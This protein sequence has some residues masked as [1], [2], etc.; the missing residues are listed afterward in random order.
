M[1]VNGTVNG[2]SKFDR[3]STPVEMF[4]GNLIY[5]LHVSLLVDATRMCNNT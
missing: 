2:N 3:P 1:A 5:E 4:L